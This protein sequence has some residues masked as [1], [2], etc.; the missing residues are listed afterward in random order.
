M[1]GVSEEGAVTGQSEC[2][3]LNSWRRCSCRGVEVDILL[4]S[5]KLEGLESIVVVLVFQ[6]MCSYMDDEEKVRDSENR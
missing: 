3:I 5:C 1:T 6:S 2:V 4:D